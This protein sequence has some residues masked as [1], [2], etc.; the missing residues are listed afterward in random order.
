MPRFRHSIC[1]LCLCLSASALIAENYW[2]KTDWHHWSKSDCIRMLSDSPWAQ[3]WG[4]GKSNLNHT[5]AAASGRSNLGVAGEQQEAV[6]Y[7]IQ[8]LSAAPI[9]EALARQDQLDKKYDKM[10]DEQKKSFD[11]DLNLKY[12]ATNYANVIAI[13]VIY[14]SNIEPFERQLAQI[15]QSFPENSVPELTNL[16][17]EDGRRIAPVKFSSPKGAKDEFDLEF[18]RF[19]DGKP[20]IR[21]EDKTLGLE[22]FHP[23]ITDFPRKRA[24]IVF[25]IP[26]MMVGNALVY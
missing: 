7:Y 17:L 21:P 12:F 23:G 3:V 8:F 18:P 10:T 1:F 25:T 9:R 13:D 24:F 15:W 2:S 16:I 20:I 11:A 6:V 5:L 19:V 26:K 4:I 14:D 22:F